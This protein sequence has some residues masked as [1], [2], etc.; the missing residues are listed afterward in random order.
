MAGAKM[1]RQELTDQ[2]VLDSLLRHEL[3]VPVSR[4]P[5]GNGKYNFTL[6][7]DEDEPAKLCSAVVRVPKA[8]VDQVLGDVDGCFGL[9]AAAGIFSFSVRSRADKAVMRPTHCLYG[10]GKMPAPAQFTLAWARRQREMEGQ[11][12]AAATSKGG[13]QSY[14]ALLAG[15]CMVPAAREVTLDGNA[16]TIGAKVKP[17]KPLK[18][19]LLLGRVKA[20]DV[21]QVAE[22]TSNKSVALRHAMLGLHEATMTIHWRSF[23]TS[24]RYNAL[25]A[26]MSGRALPQWQG[27]TA[28]SA[29]VVSWGGHLPLGAHDPTRVAIKTAAAFAEVSTFAHQK[30]LLKHYGFKQMVRGDLFQVRLRGH[31]YANSTAYGFRLPREASKAGMQLTLP[32]K[33]VHMHLLDDDVPDSVSGR[34]VIAWMRLRRATP[35]EADMPLVC[36]DSIRRFSRRWVLDI[37]AG[38]RSFNLARLFASH[39]I[40]ASMADL[41]GTFVEAQEKGS[42]HITDKS[43]LDSLLRGELRVPLKRTNLGSGTYEFVLFADEKDPSKRCGLELLVPVAIMRQTEGE[44]DGCF[45]LDARIGV[46]EVAVK[47]RTDLAPVTTWELLFANGNLFK[48]VDH[49]LAWARRCRG[50]TGAPVAKKAGAK[51]PGEAVA[52]L[53][54]GT[55]FVPEHRQ[56][57]LLGVSISIPKKLLPG[58]SLLVRLQLG[59]KAADN[60]WEVRDAAQG[61]TSWT[62]VVGQAIQKPFRF[63]AGPWAQLD[64]RVREEQ[65]RP[66]PSSSSEPVLSSSRARAAKRKADG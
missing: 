25:I 21:W 27:L 19:R 13:E 39:I 40:Q 50:I 53:L 17:C 11:N 52:E 34:R 9:D 5:A 44:V 15:E 61:A 48:N 20:G 24:Q 45:K 36:P 4:L 66:S 10:N 22:A 8:S 28:T 32:A 31:A 12:A 2:A 65:A 43:I 23:R 54:A 16:V 1:T 41:F 37:T 35:K 63:D 47:E 38:E 56:P 60:A 57:R 46:C 51:T 33:D 3:C 49:I 55:Y 59:S 58:K 26:T 7:L 64:A 18:S 29:V 6:H 30:W 14:R 62:R 42:M